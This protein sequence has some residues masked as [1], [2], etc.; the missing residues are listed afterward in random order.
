M[1]VFN[2]DTG[3]YEHFHSLNDFKFTNSTFVKD[4]TRCAVIINNDESYCYPWELIKPINISGE[5]NVSAKLKNDQVKSIFIDF[6]KNGYSTK[7]VKFYADK[8]NVSPGTII[9]IVKGRS[10]K[11]V[12]S[13]MLNPT[14]K[15]KCLS[16]KNSPKKNQ[17]IN[18]SIANFIFRDFHVHKVS[19]KE[20]AKKYCLSRRSVQRIVFG[21]AWKKDTQQLSFTVT[22]WQD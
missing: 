12:T 14:P 2:I 22:Q 20:L 7:K 4:G 6:A 17:K 10:W 9:D 5:N 11:K 19:T 15:Y 21:S 13:E 3:N 18:G 8:H 16:A 1:K